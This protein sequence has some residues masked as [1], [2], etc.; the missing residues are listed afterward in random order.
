MKFNTDFK[1][2]V[3]V[4][5]SCHSYLSITMTKHHDQRNLWKKMLSDGLE[6]QRVSL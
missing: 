2:L 4:H 1:S 5:D 6:F 3:Y